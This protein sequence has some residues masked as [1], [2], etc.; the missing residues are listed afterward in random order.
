LSVVEGSDSEPDLFLWT[1]SAPSLGN[2]CCFPGMESDE[3]E[4]VFFKI[5]LDFVADTYI[6][7]I[8]R[9]CQIR[10]SAQLI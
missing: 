3:A 9:L 7:F 5:F 6:D 2:L 8:F 10:E 1:T 4:F